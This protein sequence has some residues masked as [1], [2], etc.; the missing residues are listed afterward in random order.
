MHS[1]IL[2]ESAD[3]FRINN[4]THLYSCILINIY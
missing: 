2:K 3:V 4:I 1:G